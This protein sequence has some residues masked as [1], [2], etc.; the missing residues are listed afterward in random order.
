[1]L[2]FIGPAKLKKMLTYVNGFMAIGM[3]GVAFINN[4]LISEIKGGGSIKKGLFQ[5][6][7]KRR[8]WILIFLFK[9]SQ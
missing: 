9:L 5:R 1:M 8:L 4:F 7:Q 2:E 3:K 6:T